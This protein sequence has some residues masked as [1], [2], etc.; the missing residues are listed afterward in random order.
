MN[1]CPIIDSDVHGMMNHGAI[2]ARLPEP[3]RTRYKQGNRGFNGNAYW[4]PNGVNR[5]DAVTE[6]GQS[7][8]ADPKLLAK[9]HFDAF[10]ISYGVLTPGASLG[11]GISPEL[12]YASKC[13]T[14][15]NDTIIEDWLSA[16]DRYVGSLTI[17]PQDPLA[18][19]AEI[20]RIGDHPR[21]KQV[22]M[23]S[24]SRIPFGQRIYWPIY[25][26]ACE[27]GLPI[28]IHP[29]MEGGGITAPPSGAGYPGSYFEWH[30][31]IAASYVG[32]LC[33]VIAEGVFQQFPALKFI[34][35]EGGVSWIPPVLWRMDKNWKA[36]RQ[37]VPYLDRLPSEIAADH[38]RMTTQ[39]IEEPPKRDYLHQMLAMFPAD[40]MLMFSTDYPHW[41][42]DAPDFT[43]RNLPESIRENVLYKT[44][45]DTYGLA[46]KEPAGV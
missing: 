6:D 34:L 35:M 18:A 45:A 3:Y 22:Y 39:P 24:A 26:A 37:T 23:T 16:D 2:A 21:I 9:Y 28:A 25:E 44:A 40:R 38:I 31:T 13:I 41:D 30:T 27:F 42:G 5:R 10:G 1:A 15:L 33:S 17:A 7:I 32:T 8:A 43:A 20:R 19:A 4:N 36:L 11:F 14:A 46:I 29:G 12:D